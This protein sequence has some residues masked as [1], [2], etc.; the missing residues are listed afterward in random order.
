MYNFRNKIDNK[1]N[2]KAK[3]KINIKFKIEKYSF[4]YLKERFNYTK[5]LSEVRTL[6]II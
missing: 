1:Q 6:V 2:L 3:Y 5:I 4:V